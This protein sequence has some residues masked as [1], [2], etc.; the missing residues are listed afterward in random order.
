MGRPEA[1]LLLGLFRR[2]RFSYA[3]AS[4]SRDV[5][6]SFIDASVA[7]DLRCYEE[8]D[9]PERLEVEVPGAGRYSLFSVCV[10]DRV[11]FGGYEIP[12]PTVIHVARA[13]SGGGL[14]EAYIGRDLIEYWQLYVDPSEGI[15]RSRIARRV[16]PE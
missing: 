12:V 11:V 2:N 3:R 16:R 4:V 14:F 15:V 8:V 6:V 10:V 5:K 1:T 7:N 9:L 13:V